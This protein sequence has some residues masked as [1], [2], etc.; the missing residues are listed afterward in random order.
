MKNSFSDEFASG[1]REREREGE[2]PSRNGAKGPA[3]QPACR[4]TMNGHGNLLRHSSGDGFPDLS[5]HLEVTWKNATYTTGGEASKLSIGRP[6]LATAFRGRS[7][8]DS[9][10]IVFASV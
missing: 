6:T 8:Y 4:A 3:S 7:G 5:N 9:L 10:A 1:E 2:R